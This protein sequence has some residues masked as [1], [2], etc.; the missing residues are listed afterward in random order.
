MRLKARLSRLETWLT[1]ATPHILTITAVASA[2]G[3]VISE[4]QLA[5]ASC[6]TTENQ[7]LEA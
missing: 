5:P 7:M 2:T 4:N 3:E 1:P 6:Y